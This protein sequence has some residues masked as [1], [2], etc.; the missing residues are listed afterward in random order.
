MALPTFRCSTVPDST[1]EF[2]NEIDSAKLIK[3]SNCKE[4]ARVNSIGLY[5]MPLLPYLESI[6]S[7]NALFVQ[8]SAKAKLKREVWPSRQMSQP[9][10]AILDLS[11]RQIR[12][13]ATWQRQK[14]SNG[15]NLSSKHEAR[16]PRNVRIFVSPPCPV[17]KAPLTLRFGTS[18]SA[19]YRLQG[20][21]Q[22]ATD[23]SWT[24]SNYS[25][26]T[27]TTLEAAG[28]PDEND[29]PQKW[30]TVDSLSGCM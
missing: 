24:L 1:R 18:H 20:G 10:K 27:G 21:I 3:I 17:T 19:V 7:R 4:F 15:A 9:N 5:C 28:E 14:P 25:G 12:Y 22:P 2:D 11:S 16:Q 8:A 30:M 26:P 29:K 13:L 6:A 23:G